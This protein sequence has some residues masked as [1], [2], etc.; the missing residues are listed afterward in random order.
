[1]PLFEQ[2]EESIEGGNPEFFKLEH[3]KLKKLIA[4]YFVEL[5]SL[6]QLEELT[7]PDALLLIERGFTFKHLFDH[8]TSREDKVFYPAIS[9]SLT[10]N[11]RRQ[12]WGLMDAFEASTRA[13]L[14]SPPSMGEVDN[15]I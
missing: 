5:K 10:S 9:A 11:E 2:L 14:G 12:V 1:M 6:E 4:T 13:E 15:F 7:R 8:H 3:T